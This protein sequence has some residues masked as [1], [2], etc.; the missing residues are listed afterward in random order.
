MIT[1]FTI[2]TTIQVVETSD[3]MRPSMFANYGCLARPGQAREIAN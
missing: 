3:S 2:F 1:C